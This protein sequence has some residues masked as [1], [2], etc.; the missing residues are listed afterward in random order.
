[1]FLREGTD[2]TVGF[3]GD[4]GSRVRGLLRFDKEQVVLSLAKGG[5]TS[6]YPQTGFDLLQAYGQDILSDY[7]KLEHDL[8]A[9]FVDYEEMDDYPEL[10]CLHGDSLV[11]TMEYGWKAIRDLSATGGDF[12]V[13]AYDRETKSLVPAMARNA[14]ATGPAGHSKQ[15]VRVV[16]DNGQAVVCTADHMFFTKD[17]KW[18]QACG[19]HAGQRLMPGAIRSRSLNGDSDGSY[20]EV[21]QPNS[22]S[23]IRS[24]DG[25]RWTWVH[26]LVGEMMLGAGRG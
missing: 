11:F 21:H 15:M 1:M 13:L 7:L 18:V 20:W 12:H 25:K 16:M 5:T 8:M 6:G 19:L 9:R 14:R 17:E 4:V 3:W 10:A 24:S 23:S 22:D 2:R 26:R